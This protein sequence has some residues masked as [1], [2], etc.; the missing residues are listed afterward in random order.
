MA[1]SVVS[2]SGVIRMNV[3]IDK[4][5]HPL[6]YA[7][8]RKFAKGTR[9][10][11]RLKTLA[12]ER[13]LLDNGPYTAKGSLPMHRASFQ[14]EGQ[15]GGVNEARIEPALDTALSAEDVALA[16]VRELF[17]PPIKEE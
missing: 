16:A 11:Q 4:D 8:L 9:R 12:S 15:E 5:E 2:E 3:Y 6:L 13:L 1:K 10:V 17:A 14:Q 7:E